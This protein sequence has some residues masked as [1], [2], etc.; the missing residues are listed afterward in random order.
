MDGVLGSL[1]LLPWAICRCDA[2]ARF[3]PDKELGLAG[4][5]SLGL[6]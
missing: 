4:F 5:G 3:L 2:A 6:G 1:M